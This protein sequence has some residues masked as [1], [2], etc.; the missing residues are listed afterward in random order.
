MTHEANSPYSED[1]QLEYDESLEHSSEVETE[2]EEEKSRFTE[3]QILRFSR[4]RFPGNARSFA[5]LIGKRE[6]TYGQKVVAMSDRGMAV[7]Y[8]NSFP[9]SLPFNKGMLPIRS[10]GKVATSE[11]IQKEKESYIKQKEVETICMDLIE[12]HKLDMNLT[13]VEFTQ[14]GKKA[15][16]YFTAPARI[17][18]RELVRELVSTLKLRIELR[19]ISVRDRS[20]AVGGLGPCGRE[21]CCSSFLSKYGNVGIK[22]AKNQDLSL[23]FTKL[24]GMCGQ[25]KCCLKY[26]DDVYTEK[27]KKLPEEDSFVLLVNGD[28]GKITKLHILSEQFEMITDQGFLRRYALSQFNPDLKLQTTW[29]FPDFFENVVNETATIIGLTEEE[30]RKTKLFEETLKDIPSQT[31]QFS[32]DVM[33]ELFPDNESDKVNTNSN[34]L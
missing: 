17:D 25:L 10:I 8:I 34:P 9:Y 24:N 22:M 29:K 2:T 7:G 32:L 33:N 16:F 20:A 3:N 4:V 31:S 30:T 5:F 21:L 11:D 28:K 15:V 26:E 6:F 19:Q 12:K 13:H 18:F 23:N 1:H 27:R 14:F